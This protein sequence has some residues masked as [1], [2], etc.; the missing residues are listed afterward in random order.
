[1]EHSAAGGERDGGRHLCHWPGCPKP[2]SPRYWGCRPHWFALPS[3]IR[4]RIWA[5]YRP[6]QEVD[7]KPSAAYVAAA[8]AAQRWIA[9]NHPAGTAVPASAEGGDGPDPQ[10]A[11]FA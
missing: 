2:V 10:L 8:R 1:M 7:K 6:G 3:G 11:L 9:E 4:S 5:A